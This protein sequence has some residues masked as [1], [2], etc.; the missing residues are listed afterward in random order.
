MCVARLPQHSVS[1][2]YAF[3]LTSIEKHMTS[4]GHKFNYFLL[5]KAK[6]LRGKHSSFSFN[7]NNIL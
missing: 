1:T 2:Q 6:F 3:P 7:L 4:P 5:V